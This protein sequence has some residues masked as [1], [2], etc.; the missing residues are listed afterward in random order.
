MQGES[1]TK[2][3]TEDLF[4]RS[5][6]FCASA[7]DKKLN[8]YYGIGEQS[9]IDNGR[10]CVLGTSTAKMVVQV[11]Q[12]IASNVIKNTTGITRIHKIASSPITMTSE[13]LLQPGHIVKERWKVTKKIGGGGFGEIYECIDLASKENV[14]LKVESAKQAKQVLKME[15]A[16]LKKLQVVDNSGMVV[17]GREHVCRFIGCGRNDRFNYVVMQL[18]GKNLAELRRSQSRGAF[19]LSTTLR[20]GHQILKAIESIHEVGFLHRDIKPS[21]FAIGHLSQTCRKVYMLDFGLARQ[22]TTSTGEVRAPRIVAG[23]RWYSQICIY[24]CTLRIRAANCSNF[25][26]TVPNFAGSAEMGRHDDLWSLFYMLVEFVNGQ[27]PWRK[28][29]D[30]EQVGMMKEVYD[31]RILLKHLPSDFRQFLDHI[32][33]LE[34]PDKPDYAM[35][36]GLFERC[37]KRRGVHESDPFDWE[38][39]STDNSVATTTT[40]PAVISKPIHTGLLPVG[41][42]NMLDDNIM[43]S[44]QDHG[45]SLKNEGVNND[46]NMKARQKLHIERDLH[47]CDRQIETTTEDRQNANVIRQHDYEKITSESNK[48][49]EKRSS[50]QEKLTETDKESK[51][52][53]V[54]MRHETDH[55]D[56]ATPTRRYSQ[57]RS[58]T[59]GEIYKKQLARIHIGAVIERQMATERSAG[60]PVHRVD[61]ADQ[62]MSYLS[63]RAQSEISRTT[64]NSIVPDSKQERNIET[65]GGLVGGIPRERPRSGCDQHRYRRFHPSNRS[66]HLSREISITQFAVAEDENVSQQVT[67]GGG[68]GLTL[69]SQWKMS[70]DDSEETDNDDMENVQLTSPEHKPSPPVWKNESSVNPIVGSK[71]SKPINENAIHQNLL[72][73]G[74]HSDSKTPK[75]DLSKIS[76]ES[77]LEFEKQRT[78]SQEQLLSLPSSQVPEVVLPCSSIEVK[79]KSGKYENTEYINLEGMPKVEEKCVHQRLQRTCSCPAVANHLRTDICPSSVFQVLSNNILCQVDASRNIAHIQDNESLCNY[80]TIIRRHSLPNICLTQYSHLNKVNTAACPLKVDKSVSGIK[81]PDPNKDAESIKQ[82][83]KTESSKSHHNASSRLKSILKKPSCED[84]KSNDSSKSK[85]LKQE[86]TIEHVDEKRPTI[87]KQRRISPPGISSQKVDDSSVYYDAPSPKDEGF[88]TNSGASQT[89]DVNINSD[90]IGFVGAQKEL[91]TLKKKDLISS[92]VQHTKIYSSESNIQEKLQSTSDHDEAAVNSESL[93]DQTEESMHKASV[94]N[95]AE[96]PSALEKNGNQHAKENFNGF[97]QDDIS[98]K[99]TPSCNTMTNSNLPLCACSSVD[100]LPSKI[101]V[102]TMEIT[103]TISS[104]SSSSPCTSDAV[105]KSKLCATQQQFEHLRIKDKSLSSSPPSGPDNVLTNDK[106]GCDKNEKCTDPNRIRKWLDN[107]VDNSQHSNFIHLGKSKTSDSIFPSPVMY[108]RRFSAEAESCPQS[109]VQESVPSSSTDETDSRPQKPHDMREKYVKEG[110]E[111]KLRFIRRRGLNRPVSATFADSKIPRPNMRIKGTS[112]LSPQTRSP[113]TSNTSLSSEQIRRLSDGRDETTESSSPANSDSTT[114]RRKPRP[115]EGDA[116][117]GSN[118]RRRRYRPLSMSEVAGLPR[119]GN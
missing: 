94:I 13:D 96:Q 97:A 57:P 95:T 63:L 78:R 110:N 73:N 7:L 40:S 24:Q 28:I 113:S 4:I 34:Y 33:N 31:H 104:K 69:V 71:E 116:P 9:T 29:K 83:S 37:M 12:R 30:K 15:V 100:S 52:E 117:P 99:Q 36:S 112:S 60:S 107:G 85:E 14:A 91:Q 11:M 102:R 115:P 39:N 86:I 46:D 81:I 27:L 21:N 67:K 41:T 111:L 106:K 92:C 93:Q 61:N 77:K 79:N 62:E 75:V 5:L 10:T 2:I 88:G 49:N 18:Q 54:D 101:P 65:G 23:F 16:V 56:R 53:D 70:F 58:S 114:S 68:G 76:E 19:S 80:H 64:P 25:C 6:Q 119:D 22:Y 105:G 84:S 90:K 109:L 118:A 87:L 26:G 1:E 32:S 20:L 8:R 48:K 3:N 17:A 42:E 43:A 82:E 45:G 51:E 74:F 59:D 47:S 72:T 98:K 35:L 66:R 103:E 89:K 108:V 50:R 44:Y 38:K 55:E